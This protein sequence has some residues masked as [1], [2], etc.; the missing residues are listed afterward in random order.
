MKDFPLYRSGRSAIIG[1]LILAVPLLLL[2]STPLLGLYAV[3]IVLFLS[4]FT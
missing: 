3:L 2:A 1:T 4:F